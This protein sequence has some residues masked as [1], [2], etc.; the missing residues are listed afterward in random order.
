MTNSKLISCLL[1][2]Y[3]LLSQLLIGMTGGRSP[4]LAQTPDNRVDPFTPVQSPKTKSLS[5]RRPAACHTSQV[6]PRGL[7]SVPAVTTLPTTGKRFA[8]I[9]GVDSY[10]DA[11]INPLQGAGKDAQLLADTLVD[12]SG[13]DRQQVFVLTSQGNATQQPYRANVLQR[14]AFIGRSIPKDGLLLVAFSGHGVERQGKAFLLP[15]DARID[16]DPRLLSETCLDVE[17]LKTMIRGFGIQ[18]VL[19]LI[20]TCRNEVV[21]GR[22]GTSDTLSSKFTQAFRFEVRNR[23]VRAFATLYAASEGERAFEYS[24]KKHGYF[25]WAL[26]EGLRGAAQNSTGQITLASLVNY[27]QTQ[28]PQRVQYELGKEQHP[29]AEIS[30]YRADQLVLSTPGEAASALSVSTTR[31]PSHT[32][33]T[34]SDP[35]PSSQPGPRLQ[36]SSH[37]HELVEKLPNGLSLELAELPA[38]SFQMGATPTEASLLLAEFQTAGISPALA[39]QLTNWQTSGQ[40][41]K[42]APLAISRF[43]ITQAV[44]QVV[45]HLPKIYL[46]LPSNPATMQGDRLPVENISWEEANEFCARLSHLTGKKYR[47]PTE[48]E[49]EYACRAGSTTAFAFGQTLS[50]TQANF[51]ARAGSH[52]SGSPAGRTLPVGSVGQ[53]NQFGL[54]DMHG[55]VWEWCLDSWAETSPL[56]DTSRVQPVNLQRSTTRTIRGG[57]WFNPAVSCRSTSRLGLK[58]TDRSS[59]VGFRVVLEK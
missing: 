43:E 39:K 59:T 27:L 34:Y 30:G 56:S 28:V 40:P 41:V 10:T 23:E 38:G 52:T 47:L 7:Q 54:F 9:I 42:V 20:D 58:S 13:F 33:I 16:T 50:S 4:V 35:H 21:T 46:E 22:S 37:P 49:W 31:L 53:P 51:D 44:W 45:A 57:S 8:L 24:D 48:A 19:F 18:Q 29:F 25:T 11:Q 32:R 1:I 6:T 12:V 15:S 2:F 26:V 17:A 5:T 14:L 36:V 3:L 55:N